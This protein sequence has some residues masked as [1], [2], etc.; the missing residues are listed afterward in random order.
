MKDN[1]QLQNEPSGEESRFFLSVDPTDEFSSRLLSR[2]KERYHVLNSDGTKDRHLGPKPRF[3]KFISS[4]RPAVIPIVLFLIL[5]GLIGAVYAYTVYKGY[6]PGFGTTDLEAPF[7][8]L[9]SPVSQTRDGVELRI[10]SAIAGTEHTAVVY[11]ISGVPASAIPG[12]SS[13]MS[14]KQR[15]CGPFIKLILPDD[16][17]LPSIWSGTMG[18]SKEGAYQ[19]IVLFETLP[20]TVKSLTFSLTCIEGTMSNTVPENWEVAFNLEKSMEHLVIWEP[21]A[22]IANSSGNSGAHI[23]INEVFL[24]E[25]QSLFIGSATDK[26]GKLMYVKPGDISFSNKDGNKLAWKTPGDIVLNKENGEGGFFAYL[27][28]ASVSEFPISME[29][30]ALTG[31]CGGTALLKLDISGIPADGKDHPY[32]TQMAFNGCNVELNS[33]TRNAHSLVLHLSAGDYQLDG[34]TVETPDESSKIMLETRSPE[35]LL[36]NIITT[37]EILS[38]PPPFK[39]EFPSIRIIGPWTIEIELKQGE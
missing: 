26:S 1:N 18:Y 27:V 15:I 16:S 19:K 31:F 6:L 37:E 38:N 20:E 30:G 2:L 3:S 24:F 13:P 25:D 21:Q 33:I 17:E 34:I 7:R 8:V 28:D 14:T 32:S 35:D 39:L 4:F 9:P 12:E 29:I 22:F 36:V 5:F 10:V 23:Q 11:S